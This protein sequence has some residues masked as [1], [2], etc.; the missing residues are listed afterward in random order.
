MTISQHP[1]WKDATVYQ[2]YPASFQDSNGDGIGDLRG[3]I[4]RLE[5]IKSIGVDVIWVCPMYQSPQIDMGY[6]ISDYQAVHEPYGTVA[7][8]EELIT[9]VHQLGMRI[10]L[11]LVVNHTSDQHAWQV[12]TVLLSKRDWYIWK[13]AKYDDSGNRKP[14]NNWRSNFG[15]SAWQWDEHTQEYYLHLFCPEQPD[16]NWDN[17]ETR[18]AI[19]DNAMTFWLEKGCDGFR[20]DTVN[21]YSKDPGFP[22]APVTDPDAE[23]QE[24]GLV[25]CNGPRMNEY[26]MEMNAI[27]SRYD[28][29]TVGECPFTPDQKQVHGYVSASKKRLNMVF[30]FD[31][32]D[33]GQGKVF[34]YGTTPFAYT[35]GDLKA[36][37]S[38]TQGLI[39]DSDAW[40]TSFVENH[41]QARSVSRFGNDSPQWRE[42][43]AKMLALLFA[44]LS[45]TLFVYQGQEIGMINMPPEWPIEEYK[46]VDSMNYYNMVAQ[47]GNNDGKEL[48]KAKAALQHLARDHA[49]TPMQWDASSN[50]GF[51]DAA[52]SWMRVNTSTAE[53]NVEQQRASK[54]SVLSF[55]KQMLATRKASSNTLIH[56]GFEL[57]DEGNENVFSFLK[58]GK[59][60]SALIMCNFSSCANQVPSVALGKDRVVLFH[61][62]PSTPDESMLAPWEGRIYALDATLPH[63]S[64]PFKLFYNI[65]PLSMDGK[66]Q[67]HKAC[68]ACSSRKVRCNGQQRC[69]QCEHLNLRCEYPP[70]LPRQTKQKTPITGLKSPLKSPGVPGVL[71]ELAA[72]P[73]VQ[74]YGDAHAPKERTNGHDATFFLSLLPDFE[75]FVLP[76]HPVMT[77][78]EAHD[79]IATMTQDREAEAF[80]YGLVAITLNLTH[81]PR[82]QTTAEKSD[83]E[84]WVSRALNTLPPVQSQE[85]ISV[86]R[87]ATLQ[88]IHVCL[89]GLGRHGV[90][91]YYLRQSTTMLELLN[92][93][94]EEAMSQLSLTERAQRQ[95]LYWTI[96]V[97]ERFYAITCQRSI[98]LPPLTTTSIESD[99]GI[100]KAITDGFEQIAR[101][102]CH[103]DQD[104]L[105][106]WFAT[107]GSER[108]IEPAW[109]VE[110]NRQIDA[111]T[112]GNDD[113]IAEL[114]H[115]QQADLIITK[116]WLRMMIWQMAISNCLLSSD[117]SEQSMSLLFPVHVSAQL[118]ALIINMTKGAIEVHGSGIQQKLFELTDTIASVILT[119]PASST[120]EKRQRMDD[121]SFLFEFWKSLPRPNSVQTELLESKFRRLVEI[122]L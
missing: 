57:I 115:M 25:Y 5:Y 79:A 65:T 90:A 110:K 18:Q 53:I 99:P 33:V 54:D 40:T 19:Y 95:R 10:I 120:D 91:F 61:N 97:H 45:G 103:I 64:E 78:R 89:M 35:L 44:S 22:D 9:K 50:G 107:F 94:D 75:T 111:E 47:R 66:R 86:R 39:H 7:D 29:M 55:W 3:I 88:F 52:Q 26:L 105:S 83:I 106:R 67:R 121:F 16:L 77:I 38:R 36:A 2:I 92:V 15:G 6:D 31:L 98:V 100:P 72:A 73:H 112:A 11:D 24:A 104:M 60:G 1:W 87:L 101:L 122:G 62:L 81:S 108:F 59:T 46:D 20:V 114:S 30:Q 118:R 34:K 96:F 4:N 37:I 43:S 116:H 28:A 80:I 42:R 93:G 102:F 49:R 27:L 14:P 113:E 84:H 41:D 119:V 56:G 8:M 13:P 58:H 12:P 51:T 21:M 70:T 23:W 85:D 63:S 32:V 71:R 68:K 74:Q 69:Q 48:S 82:S 109:I 76:F 117:R 17:E